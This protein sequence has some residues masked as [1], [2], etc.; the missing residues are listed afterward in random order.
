MGQRRKPFIV[1]ALLYEATLGVRGEQALP[2][3]GQLHFSFAGV[4]QLADSEASDTNVR[5]QICPLLNI[6]SEHQPAET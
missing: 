5:S 1:L 6:R 2:G 3:T 4:H